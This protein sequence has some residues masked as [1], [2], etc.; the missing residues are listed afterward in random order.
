VLTNCLV[1]RLR[2]VVLGASSNIFP[3]LPAQEMLL[4]LVS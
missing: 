2:L 3:S 4:P 1:V